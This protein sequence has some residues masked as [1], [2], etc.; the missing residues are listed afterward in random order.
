MAGLQQLAIRYRV[1]IVIVHHLRKEGAEDVLDMISGTT[2]ISGAADL[3]LVLTRTKLGVR[4]AGRGRDTEEIDKLAELDPETSIWSITGD[5]DEAAPDSV[6]GSLRRLIYELLDNSPL[7]LTAP[8]IAER[9]GKPAH[10][11]R[12]VL[13]RMVRATPCQIIRQPDGSYITPAKAERNR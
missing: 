7:P 4:L 9:L 6:M 8:K 3:A 5:Y 10:S 12:T 1:A 2:G 11:V 13:G